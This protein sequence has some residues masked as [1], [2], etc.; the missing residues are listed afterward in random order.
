[1]T[2]KVKLARNTDHEFEL[3]LPFESEKAMDRAKVKFRKENYPDSGIKTLYEFY[4]QFMPDGTKVEDIKNRKRTLEEDF[5]AKYGPEEGAKKV[6]EWKLNRGKAGRLEGYIEKYGPKI[7]KQKYLEKNRKLSVGEATLRKNGKTE[8]EIAEIKSKHG[9]NSA[10]T[11]ENFVNSYGLEE[12]TQRFANYKKNHYTY[13]SVKYW[14]KQGLTEEEAK[15]KISEWQR[16]DLNHFITKYGEQEGTE[17]YLEANKLKVLNSKGY[18]GLEMDVYNYIKTLYPKSVSQFTIKT[19]NT[20]LGYL[21]DIYI[22]ELNL[23][24]EVFGDYFHCNPNIWPADKY[25]K[26]LQMTGA[27]K[28]E[29][30]KKR[31]DDIKNA[32][33]PVEVIW[34]MELRE[35]FYGIINK[36]LEKYS[37]PTS[38][39]K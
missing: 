30:D 20:T 26:T 2:V 22:P 6:E 16:R 8:E 7:G 32:G 36:I 27:E 24:I 18:S 15:K 12:G 35:D 39:T 13:T 25:N 19:K 1:M 9:K 23:V 37:C 28:L 3:E 31:L 10:R 33:Y 34:E 4:L 38:L 21:P 14:T 29:K 5:I 17:R 11:L